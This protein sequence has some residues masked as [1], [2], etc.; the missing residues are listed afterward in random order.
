MKTIIISCLISLNQ[1]RKEN[2][3]KFSFVVVLVNA[4]EEGTITHAGINNEKNL[5]HICTMTVFWGR[6]YLSMHRSAK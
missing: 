2:Q 5:F 6:Q 3:A 4:R 1:N